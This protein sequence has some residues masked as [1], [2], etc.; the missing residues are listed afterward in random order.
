[1]EILYETNNAMDMTDNPFIVLTTRQN[2]SPIG[3]PKQMATVLNFHHHKK[4]D[5]PKDHDMLQ[6]A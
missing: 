6:C 1:M 3:T 2:H 4:S 5:N